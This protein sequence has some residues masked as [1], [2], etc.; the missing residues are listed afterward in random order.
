MW[1]AIAASNDASRNGSSCTS[2]TAYSARSASTAR[3]ASTMPGE[4]SVNVRRQPGG[5]RSRF[6]RQMF[7]SP[8]PTSSTSASSARTGRGG[9]S[10]PAGSRSSSTAARPSRARS[11][12]AS[13]ARDEPIERLLVCARRNETTADAVPILDLLEHPG[14]CPPGRLQNPDPPLALRIV[15][16]LSNPLVV[17][18]PP[19][20]VAQRMVGRYD[21]GLDARE[22]ERH[23][24]GDAG[25][26]AAAGAVDR[27]G[28][29]GVAQRRQRTC[30]GASI[31][32]GEREV[33][34]AH[35]RPV[36]RRGYR[37]WIHR[38]AQHGNG[39]RLELVV[40]ILPLRSKIDDQRN[41]VVDERLPTGV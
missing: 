17:V 19:A 9:R 14:E 21:V 28:R 8:Q 25:A 22:P 10:A 3:A 15:G 4:K 27:S 24:A 41:A 34:L 36:P 40:R 5:M 32:V 2:A 30:Q 16:R 33:R 18:R 29:I 11:R 35:R 7:A 20:L 13:Q 23:P 38:L 6:S 39:E 12:L 31:L 26:V 1:L 37:A